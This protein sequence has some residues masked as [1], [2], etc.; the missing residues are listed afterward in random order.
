MDAFGEPYNGYAD[1]EGKVLTRMKAGAT[2]DLIL[3]ALKNCF[4][5]AL[6]GQTVV[7]DRIKRKQLFAPV[8]RALVEEIIEELLSK[9]EGGKHLK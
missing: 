7:I 1:L 8:S 2:K 4:G 9:S 3:G 6:A 5:T